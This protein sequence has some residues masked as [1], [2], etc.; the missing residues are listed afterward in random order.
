MLLEKLGNLFF[1]ISIFI[2]FWHCIIIYMYA[3]L[4]IPTISIQHTLSLQGRE[5][6]FDENNE[7][8][9]P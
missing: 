9:A 2:Y 8:H 3:L 1:I 7:K 5:T 6:V 4:Y